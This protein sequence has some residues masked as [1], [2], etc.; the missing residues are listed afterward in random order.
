MRVLVVEDSRVL[1]NS[2]AEGLREAGYA[3]DA[4]PD[5]RQGLIQTCAALLLAAAIVRLGLSAIYP[6]GIAA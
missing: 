6:Q 2:L 3:V 4:V 5:G 1:R